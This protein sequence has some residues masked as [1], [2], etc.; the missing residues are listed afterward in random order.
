MET[1]L[2]Q[3]AYFL[4]VTSITNFWTKPCERVK[5]R[6]RNSRPSATPSWVDPTSDPFFKL[7]LSVVQVMLDAAVSSAEKEQRW[8]KKWRTWNMLE[9][10][11]VIW[12]ITGISW[13]ILSMYEEST[14]REAAFVFAAM[15]RFLQVSSLACADFA[16]FPINTFLEI[17]MKWAL[18]PPKLW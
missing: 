2:I 18:K 14:K 11:G 15:I 4:R 5:I 9:Y 13:H 3:T 16:W 7:G 17:L 8:R 10:V 1:N 12:N 6:M